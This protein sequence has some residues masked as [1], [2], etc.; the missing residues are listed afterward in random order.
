MSWLRE[1]VWQLGLAIVMAFAGAALMYAGT[2]SGDGIDLE[3][4]AVAGILVFCAAL[5]IPLVSKAMQ[6]VQ[7][8]EDADA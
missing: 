1:R 8:A 6:T 5:A 2:A 3:P 4:V 7:E